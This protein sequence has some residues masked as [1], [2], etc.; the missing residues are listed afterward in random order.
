MNLILQTQILEYVVIIRCQGRIVSGDEVRTLQLEVEKLTHFKKRVVLQLAEVSYV[1]SAG[2]GALVR[3]FG[4]LRFG[5]GGLK[6]CQLSPFV[7]QVLQGTNLLGVIP[8]Y[9][10]EKEAIEAFSE[11]P[12]PLEKASRTPRT[13]IVCLDSSDD[14]LAYLKALLTRAGYEVFTTRHL[15]DA[16]TLVVAT[17][18]GLVIFGP[19]MQTSESVIEKFH[20]SDPNLQVLLLPSDFSAAEASQAGTELLNRVRSVLP[21]Q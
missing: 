14:L 2:L 9:A 3:L 12:G 19:G 6:L 1:D 4:V 17:R 8:T 15:S 16:R 5:G 18:P 7:L 20:E 21:N 11:G 13:K 10:S